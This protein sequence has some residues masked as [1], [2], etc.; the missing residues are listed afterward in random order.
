MFEL[1]GT[2]LTGG[3]TG[4]IGSVIGKLFG[5]V[6]YYVEEKKAD[7]DHIR[8]IEMLRLQ[9]EIGAEENEREMAVAQADADSNMRMASY[10]HDAMAGTSSIWVANILRLV[11]PTLTLG[12]IVL[13]GILYFSADI[14]GR[15]T[16]EAS[17]IYMTSSS[18]LW[19]FGDRA[20]RPKK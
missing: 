17:V 20:L 3:A 1:I 18:V 19:W 8:T 12:L 16:I 14:G 6:D 11:R 13:V 4:V 7:K 10:Q 2:V 5:F 9:N 15:A